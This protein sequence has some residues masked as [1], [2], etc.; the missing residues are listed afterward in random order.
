MPPTRATAA[1]TA[2][3]KSGRLF[4]WFLRIQDTSLL[5]SPSND[6]GR[7]VEFALGTLDS[8]IPNRPDVHIYTRYKAD[9]LELTDGL[10]AY[11]EG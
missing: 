9:G 7:R 10:P 3:A 8:P 1:R 4:R 5:F 11:P 2:G 6:D